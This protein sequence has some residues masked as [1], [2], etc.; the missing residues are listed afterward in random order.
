MFASVLDRKPKSGTLDSELVLEKLSANLMI[1]DKDLFITYVNPALQ[2]LL[3]GIESDL[4]KDLPRF[5]SQR[6]IGENIDV[7]HKQPSHQRS[8]LASLN[9][10]YRTRIQVGGR[11]LAFTMVSLDDM[12]PAAQPAS[13]DVLALD[14]ALDAL[15]SIDARQA[16]VVELRFFAGLNIDETA[17]ALGVSPATIDNRQAIHP[18]YRPPNDTQG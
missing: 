1:A 5:D 4:K 14:Q 12:S 15:A 2:R 7:F 13:V 10:Q 9:G 8:L 17:E 3:E 16:H 6:L 18:A 11:I